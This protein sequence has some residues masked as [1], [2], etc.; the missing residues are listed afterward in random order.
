MTPPPMTTTRARSGSGVA[1]SVL[2]RRLLQEI[3]EAGILEL[4]DRPV[5]LLHR[6]LPEVELDRAHRVLD[7]APEGPAVLGH[8]PPEPRPRDPVAQH[9]A[10]VG[11]HQLV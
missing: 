3:R 9:R 11:L 6:P 7:G 8:Q 5:V 1:T 10:V 4:R 2:P